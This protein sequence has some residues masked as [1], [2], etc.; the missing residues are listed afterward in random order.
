MAEENDATTIRRDKKRFEFC[1]LQK[2][3]VL[4]GRVFLNE[5]SFFSSVV[6]S[7]GKSYRIV[8]ELAQGNVSIAK[9]VDLDRIVRGLKTRENRTS[10]R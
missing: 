8:V 9:S 6:G 4:R 10:T 3:S 2:S 7:F 5:R 1:F